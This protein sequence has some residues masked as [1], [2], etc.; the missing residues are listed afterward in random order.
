MAL[1][2]RRRTRDERFDVERWRYGFKISDRCRRLTLQALLR[3]LAR[4]NQKTVLKS[5]IC[6]ANRQSDTSVRGA[7]GMLGAQNLDTGRHSVQ[8]SRNGR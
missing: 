2:G 7:D 1:M 3:R 8:E 4:K 6:G 5:S